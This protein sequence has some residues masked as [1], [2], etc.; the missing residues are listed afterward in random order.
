MSRYDPQRIWPVSTGAGVKVAVI[1]SGVDGKHP[2]LQG[3]VL[4]GLDLLDHQPAA[5]FD[6]A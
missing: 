1:D 2:Q 4:G 3:K 5:S 6:T